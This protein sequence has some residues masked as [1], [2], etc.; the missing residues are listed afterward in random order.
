MG[1]MAT[2]R[3]YRRNVRPR[4][5]RE[6]GPATAGTSRLEEIKMLAAKAR[7]TM[8]GRMKAGS[9]MVRLG[10]HQAPAAVADRQSYK[11]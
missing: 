9:G 4:A 3:P 1:T 8:A 11:K 6:V 5:S 7:P 10:N 2:A